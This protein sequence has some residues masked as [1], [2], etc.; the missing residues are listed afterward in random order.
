M[1]IVNTKMAEEKWFTNEQDADVKVLLRRFPVSNSL[2]APDDDDRVMKLAWQRFEYC[3]VDWKGFLDESDAKLECNSDN[4]KLVFDY[5]V[6]TL[7][8]ISGLVVAFDHPEDK[9]KP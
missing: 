3:I 9:K 8:W 6:D 7:M 1:K 4:K 2:F 5:D